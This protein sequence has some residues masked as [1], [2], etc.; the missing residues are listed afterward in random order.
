MDKKIP[1]R[2]CI[3]CRESKDKKSLVRIVK[4]DE[5]FV[6]DKTG[7]LNGRGSY[8]CNSIEC[9]N[10]LIKQRV[11]N[12]VFK[13]NIPQEVYDDLKEKLVGLQQD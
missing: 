4:T 3:V 2:M 13:C 1:Q 7:K 10:L 11:L 8:V 6:V 12:K 5:G 9:M